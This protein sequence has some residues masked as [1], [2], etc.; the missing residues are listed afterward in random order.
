MIGNIDFGKINMGLDV[1]V[2][3][4]NSSQ[5]LPRLASS[6]SGMHLNGSVVIV[7]NASS[8]GSPAVAEGLQWGGPLRVIANDENIGFGAA[9]N[10]GIKSFD[11]GNEFLLIVNPDVQLGPDT[12]PVL[13]AA[14]ASDSRL[15]CV[16]PQLVTSDGRPVSS[17]RALPTPWTI[18][19]RVVR[20]QIPADNEILNVGWVCGA[21]MLWRR[22]AFE[23]I[24]GFSSEYFLYFEDVDI[25]RKAWEADLRVATVS[26]AK[27]IH[28]QG[29]GKEPSQLL[30]KY[31]DQSRRIYSRKWL[32]VPGNVAVTI[33]EAVEKLASIRRPKVGAL[34]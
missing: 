2:V 5:Y 3:S 34:K 6:L 27:A 13:E 24:G 23:K 12:L 20:E 18:A 7:D 1:V 28:D 21:V 31:S 14:L 25:C 17:A 9:M 16:G 33:A 10:Q 26:G 11:S 30:K 19:S 8:D 4:Y 22:S 15:A 32:G 29:H